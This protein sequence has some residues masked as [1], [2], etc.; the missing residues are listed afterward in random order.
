MRER[1]RE[2]GGDEGK[3]FPFEVTVKQLYHYQ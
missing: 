3:S 1:E 2:W